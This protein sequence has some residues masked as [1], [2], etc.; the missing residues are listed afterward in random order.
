MSFFFPTGA[1][2]QF[3]YLNSS[4]FFKCNCAMALNTAICYAYRIYSNEV[5]AQFASR[6]ALFIEVLVLLLELFKAL[7]RNITRHRK[8]Q[9]ETKHRVSN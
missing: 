4:S 2:V 9:I 6:K 8:C 7:Q 1:P 3:S 5:N